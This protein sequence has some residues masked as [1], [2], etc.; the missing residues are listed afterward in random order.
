MAHALIY[1]GAD[2]AAQWFADAWPGRTFPSLE[3]VLLHTTEGSGWPSY[4]RG[5]TAPN[6]TAKPD[7]QARRLLWRQHFPANM[8][9]RALR[10]TRT[11]PTNTDHVLQVELVG[12]CVP[13]WKTGLFWPQAP[14]WALEGLAAFLAWVAAEW[15][16]HLLESGVTWRAVD[17]PGDAQRLRD[18]AYDAYRGVLGH[19]HA[20]QNDHRDPGALPMKRI[21]TLAH[22]IGD[23]V[24][25]TADEVAAA[26][27]KA[28]LDYVPESQPHN[29]KTLW[30]RAYEQT[31]HN[32]TLL[33][34][35]RG[36]LA[37]LA[38]DVAERV[39]ASLPP[40]GSGV[41]GALTRVD[42]A[43]AVRQVLTEGTGG[44]P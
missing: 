26:T 31:A 7:M 20:P 3:K 10:H 44:T 41:G 29:L 21:L 25:P 8:S 28:L 36:H 33:Q 35:L 18:A 22:E 27:V 14:A 6:F 42:V 37:E 12:T 19:Q 24:M 34:D 32:T 16:D 2:T 11:Q 39:V 4:D 13:G 15:G 23:D 40:V 38:D 5:G 1:P 43:A 9:S 17:A 30:K